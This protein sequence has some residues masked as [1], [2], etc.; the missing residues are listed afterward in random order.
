MRALILTIAVAAS[1]FAELSYAGF[2]D[3][4]RFS[5]IIRSFNR[6]E[7]ILQVGKAK[8][9]APRWMFS[10]SILREGVWT[11]IAVSDPSQIRW[12]K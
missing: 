7:V 4:M 8:L 11:T 10:D 2:S 12:V 5:G 3:Q 9:A 1:F 6:R